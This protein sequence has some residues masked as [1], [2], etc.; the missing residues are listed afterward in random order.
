M[1]R[2]YVVVI[3]QPKQSA[4]LAAVASLNRPRVASV[5]SLW[6]LMC[7]AGVQSCIELPG[8][9]VWSIIAKGKVVACEQGTPAQE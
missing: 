3:I 7:Q 5:V 6:M 1:G 8:G 4:V 2:R 9:S